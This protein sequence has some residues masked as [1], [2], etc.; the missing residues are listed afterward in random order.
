MSFITRSGKN[1]MLVDAAAGVLIVGDA[2]TPLADNA[3]FKI[4]N[5]AGSSTLPYEVGRI[6]KSPDNANA[7]TPAIG[8]DLYPLTLT[9]VCKLDASLSAETGTIDVTDD[10]SEGYNAMITDGFTTISGSAGGQF[11]FDETNG[12]LATIQQKYINKFLDL[13]TDDGAGAYALTEKNDDSILLF[14][15]KNSDDIA[16]T[17]IQQW[18]LI[19][20]IITSLTMDN[21][22]KGVQNLD[23]DWTKGESPAGLY[24]RTTNATETV[25]F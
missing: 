16:V 19:E 4:V 1:A 14:I 8:D 17:H 25:I 7:I 6:F 3:W 11:K 15:L 12:A 22:L 13:Q 2:S 9:K 23:F 20:A 10:C 21:P 18:M 5:V 24:Q